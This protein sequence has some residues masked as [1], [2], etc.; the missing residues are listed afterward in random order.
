MHKQ[1]KTTWGKNIQTN[2]SSPKKTNK[3][4]VFDFKEMEIY[5]LPDR[6]IKI[7]ILKNLHDKKKEKKKERNNTDN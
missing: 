5:K 4:P 6:K 1:H 7:I 3:I 2:R